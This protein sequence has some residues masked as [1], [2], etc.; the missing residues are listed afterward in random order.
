M[1][2]AASQDWLDSLQPSTEKELALW[3]VSNPQRKKMKVISSARKEEEP[4]GAAC[5]RRASKSSYVNRAD[6]EADPARISY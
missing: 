6:A 1:A 3:K 2:E 5:T 4:F